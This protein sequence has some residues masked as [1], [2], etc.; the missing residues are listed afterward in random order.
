M[1][2][3]PIVIQRLPRRSRASGFTLLELLVALAMVAIVAVSMYSSL[4]VAFKAKAGAEISVAPG[5]ISEQAMEFLRADIV[6][7]MAPTANS[8]GYAST[9]TATAAPT[10]SQ[11]S[12]I[13]LSLA[14]SFIGSDSKDNRGHDGDDLLFYTTSDGPEHLVGDGEIKMVELTVITPDGSN[15]HVLVR[16]VTRNLLSP[17]QLTPDDEVICRHVSSFNVRYYDGTS[18]QDS[19]DSTQQ[20]NELPAAVEVTLELEPLNGDLNSPPLRFIRMFP[21]PISTVAND[22]NA[23][24]TTDTTAAGGT[25]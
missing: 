12:T 20:N 13:P 6:C 14:G 5:R 10:A 1:I 21:I 19:W 4:R 24:S 16:R 22:L 17:Q 8:I 18:W 25:P 15:D 7:A 2:R 9:S 23:T 11:S 3:R